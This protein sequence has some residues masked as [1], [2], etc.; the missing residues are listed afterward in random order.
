V[1][2]GTADGLYLV[3]NDVAVRLSGRDTHH[4]TIDG[5]VVW[6][7]TRSGL[8]TWSRGGVASIGPLAARAERGGGVHNP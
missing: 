3:E 5:D 2:V 7:G 6:V 1:W 4:I 8:E